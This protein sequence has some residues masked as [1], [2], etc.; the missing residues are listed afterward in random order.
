MPSHDQNFKN[1]IADY[2][3]QALNFMLPDQTRNWPDDVRVSL[4]RQEQLKDRLGDS[5]RELDIPLR[6]EFPDG[7]REALVIVIENES[8]DRAEFLQY[9]AIVCIHISMQMKTC[10]IVPDRFLSIPRQI[11]RRRFQPR[12]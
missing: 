10:R 2:S 4:I 3:R 8:R 7:S 9:L 12:R 5:F 6:V 11:A 1:L